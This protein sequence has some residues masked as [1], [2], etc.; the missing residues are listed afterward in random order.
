M[1]T[2]IS[3]RSWLERI[4]IFAAAIPIAIV[5]NGVRITSILIVA[6]VN[7]KFA[8]ETWH[9]YSGFFSF[10]AALALLMLLSF[11]MR[12]GFR[13]LKPKVKVTRVGE[14]STTSAPTP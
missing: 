8:A 10:A 7:H 3:N 12:K 4:V 5:A 1:K 11:V 14:P 6:Q 9:N 13:A 2:I